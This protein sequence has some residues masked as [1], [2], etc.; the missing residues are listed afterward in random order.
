M[1]K[2]NI[3]KYTIISAI[4]LF[5]TDF[6]YKTYNN[7]TYTT[8]ERCFIYRLL[9]RPFFL[10]FQ[11]FIELFIIILIGI[12][13]AVILEKA[14]LKHK[15]FYPNNVFKAFIYGSALP[16]CSCVALPLIGAFKDKIRIKVIITFLVAAP[17]LSPY[18]IALSLTVLGPTFTIIR[19]IA[20]FVLAI[21]LG[22]LI[23]FLAKNQKISLP[24]INIGNDFLSQSDIYFK[25]FKIMKIIFP[26]FLIAAFLGL[27]FEF[28][29]VEA[30][31]SKIENFNP[32]LSV[33]FAI[34]IGIPLYLCN[35]TDILILRPFFI[36]AGL[37]M[38]T[39]I[40]FSLTSTAICVSS[41]IL[42][43]KFLGKKLTCILLINIFFLSLIIGILINFF[44]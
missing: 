43:L 28:I 39:A 22:Y 34:L 30:L 6:I 27:S 5:I 20:S 41:T 12:F 16:I 36:Y 31:L 15:K 18:F 9:P 29:P 32:F 21:S 2:R 40:A 23:E 26:Y 1:S 10:F 13:I 35:G 3:I 42:L 4:F 19:I 33:F 17:L 44:F 8:K 14:Y 38:G 24:N 7:I 25:T 11:H 37:P